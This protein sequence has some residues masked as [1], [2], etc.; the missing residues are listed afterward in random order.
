MKI[1][2]TCLFGLIYSSNLFFALIL[3]LCG[4]SG[5][6]M[7]GIIAIAFYRLT[8]WTAPLAVTVVCWLPSRPK[9]PIKTKLAFNL[10]HLALSGLLFVVCYLL[11]GNW[12]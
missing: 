8:L 2:K 10:V 9:I 1:I 3:W 12:Y 11:F 5:N 4:E 7:L 6:I